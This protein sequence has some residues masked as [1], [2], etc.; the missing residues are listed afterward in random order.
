MSARSIGSEANIPFPPGRP[1]FSVTSVSKKEKNENNF[2][3]EAEC[4]ATEPRIVA[5]IY[6]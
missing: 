3:E 6:K 1:G 2:T 5:D 4:G